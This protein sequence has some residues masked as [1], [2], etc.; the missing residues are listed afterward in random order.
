MD[1]DNDELEQQ[2]ENNNN[3]KNDIYSASQKISGIAN[4][5]DVIKKGAKIAGLNPMAT[6]KKN[7]PDPKMDD[8]NSSEQKKEPSNTMPNSDTKSNDNIVSNQ[9]G[10]LKNKTSADKKSNQLKENN[11][12][13][14]NNKGKK[15]NDA[16]DG[17]SELA[18][19]L[20]RNAYKGAVKS[21]ANFIP[22]PGSGEIAE[23]IA[24][25]PLGA[26]AMR[27]AENASSVVDAPIKGTKKLIETIVSVMKK[28]KIIL[29]AIA[30]F[31]FIFIIMLVPFNIGFKYADG[32]TYTKGNKNGEIG[33]VIS[34]KYEAFY[35]NVE[36][37][38]SV[39][40]PMV[41]AVLTAYKDNEEY[42]DDA[43]YEDDCSEEELTNGSCVTKNDIISSAPKRKMKKYIKK[44]A[45]AITNSDNDVSEGDYNNPES[46]GS[47][48]FQWLYSDFIED[49]YDNYTGSLTGTE[50]ENKK[51][52]IIHFIYLYY[53]DIK[54]NMNSSDIN[55]NGGN[56]LTTVDGFQQRLSRP[57]RD[58]KFFYN[59]STPERFAANGWLEGECAW[60]ASA[61]AQEVLANF[62]NGK[63]WSYNGNG[64][65]YCDSV[66]Y[67][68]KKFA[69]GYDSTKPQVG[70][71]V[72]WKNGSYGHVAV[73]ESVSDGKVIISEAGL[74]VGPTFTEGC[75][76]GECVRRKYSAS[77]FTAAERKAYCERDNSGCFRTKTVAISEMKSL[78]R[79]TFQCYIY[80]GQPK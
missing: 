31:F 43:D 9:K 19:S 38:G 16:N 75:T 61:R 45:K 5:I 22:L 25:S 27:E 35:S 4:N 63:S 28:S 18:K 53:D 64:G 80:L 51:K 55:G 46:T 48:F 32:L 56:G 33:T 71:I 7:H 1:Y 78:Y 77:G 30:A 6:R 66:N 79:Y 8:S 42:T 2:Q 26:P 14:T 70:A 58:N 67:D 10:D 47:K 34:E 73:V 54:R 37:Y 76:N 49:Y 21:L 40:K 11:D 69:V 65:T 29:G 57:L 52:E 20:K 74:N 59:Q 3:L 62:N 60:Y 17:N 13:S 36:T 72:S 15:S 12:R 50:L 23:K 68:M 41:I 39:N 24:D 44:V